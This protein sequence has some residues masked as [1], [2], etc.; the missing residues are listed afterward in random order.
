MSIW[1]WIGALILLV[2]LCGTRGKA[3][4]GI[5]VLALTFF[6]ARVLYLWATKESLP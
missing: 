1:I 6:V 4:G 2:L 3:R 5:M